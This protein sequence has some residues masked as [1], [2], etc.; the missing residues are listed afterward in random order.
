MPILYT[1]DG[2][3]YHSVIH[4][5]GKYFGEVTATLIEGAECLNLIFIPF[6]ITLFDVELLNLAKKTRG[7][8]VCKGDHAPEPKDGVPK[9]QIFGSYVYSYYMTYSH[10]I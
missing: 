5:V 7:G 3:K 10:H 1:L 6:S 2:P 8:E 9:P 4:L